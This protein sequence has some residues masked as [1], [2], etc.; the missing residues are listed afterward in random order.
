[1]KGAKLCRVNGNQSL[2]VKSTHRCSVP[3]HH[4]IRIV[5]FTAEQ[6]SGA[7]SLQTPNANDGHSNANDRATNANF[8]LASADGLRAGVVASVD[9]LVVVLVMVSVQASAVAVAARR[10]P[11]A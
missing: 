4:H 2:G 1:M 10:L 11:R 6:I 7:P 8:R 3:G 9:A 5:A